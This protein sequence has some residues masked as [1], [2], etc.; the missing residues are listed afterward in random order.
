MLNGSAVFNGVTIS[1]TGGV[2]GT[3]AMYANPQL[4]EIL[5]DAM[6]VVFQSSGH[7][8]AYIMGDTVWTADVNKALNRYK[9]R[10]SDYE[11]G[12]RADFRNFR[13]HYYG[14]G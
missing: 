6:G 12:L 9:P 1:K 10:L 13:R 7:K 4:A 3:E 8:T 14:D 2:H 11:H 5:G